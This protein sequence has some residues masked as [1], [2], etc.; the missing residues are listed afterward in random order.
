M[1]V[2]KI[3][4]TTV[5]KFSGIKEVPHCLKLRRVVQENGVLESVCL[6]AFDPLLPTF[7][8]TTLG[9]NPRKYRETNYKRGERSSPSRSA[10]F[11]LLLFLMWVSVVKCGR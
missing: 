2:V 9:I 1:N 8:P 4:Q 10:T 7:M 6:P 5:T 11:L 3:K